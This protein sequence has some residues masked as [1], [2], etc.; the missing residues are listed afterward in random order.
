[1]LISMRDF[2][3]LPAVLLWDVSLVAAAKCRL[4]SNTAI[5]TRLAALGL[6]AVVKKY[7]WRELS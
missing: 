1:M 6:L 3:I 4:T 7:G 5:I 2:T